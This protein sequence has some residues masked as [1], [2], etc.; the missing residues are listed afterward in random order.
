MAQEGPI[1]TGIDGLIRIVHDRQKI[2]LSE[3]ASALGVSTPVA[4]EWAKLLEEEKVLK[5]EYRLTRIYLVWKGPTE[6][7]MK[8][9]I[10]K[11]DEQKA[12]ITRDLRALIERAKAKEGDLQSIRK[13]LTELAGAMDQQLPEKLRGR[14]D[15][16]HAVDKDKEKLFQE[17]MTKISDMLEKLNAIERE[18]QRKREL[19]AEMNKR[20]KEIEKTP[21]LRDRV[22]EIA[23]AR[24][25]LDKSLESVEEVKTSL[26]QALKRSAEQKTEIAGAIEAMAKLEESAKEMQ[27]YKADAEALIEKLQFRVLDIDRKL[28][29]MKDILVSGN[30][31]ENLARLRK[32]KESLEVMERE[33]DEQSRILADRTDAITKA[34][35]T[36][37]SKYEEL[38]SAKKKLIGSL[39]E[40][41]GQ[42]AKVDMGFRQE[43]GQIRELTDEMV[44]ALNKSKK[45]IEDQ[46]ELAHKGVE[47]Y[48]SAV[49]KRQ[50]V[51]EII[52]AI[53]E[54]EVERDRLVKQLRL[55]SK[56][57]SAL[58]VSAEVSGKSGKI[59][60]IKQ[61]MSDVS[62]KEKAYDAKRLQ[63]QKMIRN[64]LEEE[65]ANK[66]K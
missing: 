50:Q 19:L 32:E 12:S 23:D 17:K 35:E 21:G 3:A 27:Q 51:A 45:E 44:G 38:M 25:K 42:L 26:Q 41:D 53:D 52:D 49:A 57:V 43:A 18:I 56:S 62:L 13:E 14:L 34:L 5:L 9:N 59:T 31:S 36:H 15:A 40:Y 6:E 60:E 28:G 20:V 39:D 29:T 1:T 63:L 33:V 4:E 58:E 7:D 16:L 37:E 30:V 66:K 8:V 10:E 65:D 47:K 2:E 64:M 55:L 61:S 24:K 22:N 46:V 11:I 54:M 48:E